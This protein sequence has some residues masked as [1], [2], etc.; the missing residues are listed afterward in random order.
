MPRKKS[1]AVSEGN[2]PIPQDSYKMITREELRRILSESMGKA[3][4][5]FKKDLKS[6]DQ[7]LASLE[8]DA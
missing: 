8:Q 3:F 4:G 2:G 5:E 1:N 6:T 7:H